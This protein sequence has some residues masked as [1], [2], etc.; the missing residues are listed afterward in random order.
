MA[1]EREGAVT[2]RGNPVTLVGDEIKVGDTA[3][4]FELV[5]QDMSPVK[6]SDYAGKVL[7]LSAVPSLDTPV[8][9]T[10]TRRWD[11]ERAALGDVEML[12]VSM[13]LPMAQKRWCGAAEVGHR[14]ASSHRD[15][16]FAT[17]FGVLMKGPRLLTRAV[18]VIGKDGKVKY[19][20]YVPEVTTEPNYEAALAAAKAAK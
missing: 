5:G 14:T 2:M 8:C 18:F 11:K 4:D 1:K 10:E 20:E 16:A 7:L 9:D 12:T 17:D 6:F 13:D 3:P 19:V 15:E